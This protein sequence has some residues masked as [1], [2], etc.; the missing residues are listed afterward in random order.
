MSPAATSLGCDLLGVDRG[1]DLAHGV[2][3][4]PHAGLIGDRLLDAGLQAWFLLIGRQ[5]DPTPSL[6]G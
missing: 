2:D 5:P 6:T 3:L 4:R 1:A